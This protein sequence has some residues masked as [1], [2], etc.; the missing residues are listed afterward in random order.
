RGF[1]TCYNQWMPNP[2]TS[3]INIQDRDFALLGGLFESR[4]M[5]AAHIAALYF[6]GSKEA[7][8]KRLQKLKSAGLIGERKRRV[9]EPAV[10]FLT[11][12]GF[13]LLGNEG[14]LEDFPRL[15]A[16]AFEKRADVS[17]LTIRH[18]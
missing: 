10:L 7:G 13:S 9:N 15:S 16:T 2:H 6:G 11:R 17:A 1:A 5:T 3:P 8:K 14:Q 12:K 18:E 4:V